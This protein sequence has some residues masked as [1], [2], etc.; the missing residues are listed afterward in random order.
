[1]QNPKTTMAGYAGLVGTLLVL[2]GQ[3]KPGS[4]WGATLTQLGLLLNG[5]AAS[6]GVI[7]AKDGGH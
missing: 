2:L 5:G 7:A 3:V 1:M 6:L 4:P